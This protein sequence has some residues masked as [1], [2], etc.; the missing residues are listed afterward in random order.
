MDTW[1]NETAG[2]SSPYE[3][4]SHASFQALVDAGEAAV[5]FLIGQLREKPSF[6]VEALHRIKGTDHPVDPNN[7]GNLIGI[8]KDWLEWDTR[9]H[10]V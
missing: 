5:P 9:R 10:A 8:V 3:L 2:A 7:R 1:E 4:F 6:L